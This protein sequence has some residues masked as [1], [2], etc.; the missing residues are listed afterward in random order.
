MLCFNIDFGPDVSYSPVK[1][2]TIFSHAYS[3]YIGSGHMRLAKVETGALADR[4]AIE[5]KI[6][7]I[8]NDWHSNFRVD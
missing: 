3:C 5:A 8:H 2:G 7:N 1:L 4:V 6:K